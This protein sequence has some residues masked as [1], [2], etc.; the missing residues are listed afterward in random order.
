[1]AVFKTMNWLRKGDKKEVLHNSAER[2]LDKTESRCEK[3][4]LL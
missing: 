2:K 1:M 4:S 3:D